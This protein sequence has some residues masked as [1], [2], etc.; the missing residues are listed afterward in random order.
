MRVRTTHR[1]KAAHAKF[2]QDKGFLR[3]V[4]RLQHGMNECLPRLHR[5]TQYVSGRK[6][7]GLSFRQERIRNKKNVGRLKERKKEEA[8]RVREG[9]PVITLY[10]DQMEEPETKK[11]ALEWQILVQKKLL[12]D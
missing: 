4:G 5:Q 7:G 3:L 10:R 12:E 11:R 1:H 8:G 9:E 2:F 6:R